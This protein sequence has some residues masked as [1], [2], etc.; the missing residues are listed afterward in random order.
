MKVVF[1]PRTF[2]GLT[3]IGGDADDTIAF[4]VAALALRELALSS[5]ATSS[6]ATNPDPSSPAATASAPVRPPP[7]GSHRPARRA[8]L[9]APVLVTA[10]VTF[11]DRIAMDGHHAL[12]RRLTRDVAPRCACLVAAQM[13]QWVERLHRSSLQ[14][15]ALTLSAGLR[16]P[17]VSTQPTAVRLDEIGRTSTRAGGVRLHVSVAADDDG[18]NDRRARSLATIA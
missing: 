14:H 17:F 6:R 9:P 11:N 3:D 15:D 2:G 16:L 1:A 18:F 5:R 4:E 12:C 8:G 7:P 10:D 13:T